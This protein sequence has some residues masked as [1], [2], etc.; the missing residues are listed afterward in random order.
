MERTFRLGLLFQ[1][2]VNGHDHSRQFL[3]VGSLILKFFVHR[4]FFTENLGEDLSKK[5]KKYEKSEGEKIKKR[6][7]RGKA[8]K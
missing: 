2:P 6:G 8:E 4:S 1:T 5:K 3:Q 7:K